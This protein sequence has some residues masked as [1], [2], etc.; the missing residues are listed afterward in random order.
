MGYE[1]EDIE[2][3]SSENFLALKRAVGTVHHAEAEYATKVDR[4]ADQ[5]TRKLTG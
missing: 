3:E 2:L 1:D 5:W 4:I